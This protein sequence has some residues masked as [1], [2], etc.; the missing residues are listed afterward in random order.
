MGEFKAVRS[1]VDLSRSFFDY[2]VRGAPK[3]YH[4]A[5]RSRWIT[6]IND[7]IQGRPGQKQSLEELIA[8]LKQVGGS[9]YAGEIGV[10]CRAIQS[11]LEQKAML[12]IPYDKSS[13]DKEYK[14]RM[15]SDVKHP[16][17]IINQK[18]FDSAAKAGFP[19][20]FFRDSFFDGVTIY[21]LPD[22]T[23]LSKSYFRSSE[24]NVCRIWGANFD[25]ATFAGSGFYSCDLQQCTFCQSSI[26]NTHFR[27]S[28]LRMVSFQRASLRHSSLLDC[29]MDK[30]DFYS[31]TLDGCSLARVAAKGVR[32]LDT[33]TITF[34]GATRGECRKNKEAIYK[35]LGIPPPA[36]TEQDKVVPFP[37]KGKRQSGP[38]R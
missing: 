13:S 21:C 30:I 27:D 36:A 19:P 37:E 6:I 28:A 32:D 15:T 11:F 12:S 25:G 31:A 22:R 34:S 1:S 5:D 38:A 3:E 8:E 20:D 14:Y 29:E 9:Y 4:E 24:F 33:A 16:Q 26:S 2:L 7:I 17:K 18:L 35:A 23:D 10:L